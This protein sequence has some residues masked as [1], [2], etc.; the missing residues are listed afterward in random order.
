VVISNIGI[1]RV[2]DQFQVGERLD[3]IKL[4]EIYSRVKELKGD[5]EELGDTIRG[6]A[7]NRADLD[8]KQ[9]R[10]DMTILGDPLT[11]R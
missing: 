6:L 2:N 5:P 11:E 4:L 10:A 8:L 1:N 3:L 9:L 7:G